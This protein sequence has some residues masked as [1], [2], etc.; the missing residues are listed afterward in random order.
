M[1]MPSMKQ[2]PL[3]GMS[4]PVIIATCNCT[5]ASMHPC[6]TWSSQVLGGRVDASLPVASA[7]KSSTLI[8]A[9]VMA[10]VMVMVMVMVRQQGVI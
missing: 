9:M 1:L 6:I 3:L 5:H 2:S 4:R 7:A 10:V 8:M